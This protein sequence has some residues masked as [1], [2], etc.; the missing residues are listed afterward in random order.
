MACQGRGG[1]EL[2]TLR[3]RIAMRCGITPSAEAGRRGRARNLL[4][5]RWFWRGYRKRAIVV[6]DMS[7]AFPSLGIVDAASPTN[8]PEHDGLR[9]RI[10]GCNRDRAF[11]DMLDAI[12]EFKREATRTVGF[13]GA[14]ESALPARARGVRLGR[15]LWTVRPCSGCGPA[16]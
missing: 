13:G 6:S 3:A 11:L 7:C 5:Y 15:P 4:C 8:T 10:Q 16:E 9:P 2:S 12:E 1:A 14:S